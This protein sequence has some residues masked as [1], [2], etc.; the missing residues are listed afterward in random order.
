VSFDIF[1][2]HSCVNCQATSLICIKLIKLIPN[3]PLKVLIRSKTRYPYYNDMFQS[4]FIY[5]F[6]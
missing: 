3:G 4:T 2:N 5:W 1:L 6:T